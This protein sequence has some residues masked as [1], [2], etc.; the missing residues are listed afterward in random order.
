MQAACPKAI[1][2]PPGARFRT[3]VLVLAAAC[4]GAAAQAQQIDTVEVSG[5][6]GKAQEQTEWCWAASIQSIFLTRGLDVDQTDIV[7]TA[8]HGLVNAPA[9]GFQGTLQILNGLAMSV[10]GSTWV[11][12]AGAGPTFPNPLWLLEKFQNNEPVMIWFRDPNENHSIVLNGG[13]Y[14]VDPL[15]RFQTWITLQAY[16]PWYD[17][18]VTIP[19]GNIPKYVY[20]TFDIQLTEVSP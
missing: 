1:S 17:R 12:K 13:T 19:A 18:D 20:G 9:P 8:Y 7:K 5:F 11:V 2:S 14:T 6:Q 4:L 10:D 16:D 15:G 3:A